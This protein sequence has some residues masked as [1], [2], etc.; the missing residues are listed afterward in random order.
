MDHL[1][2]PLRTLD[3]TSKLVF[4]CRCDPSV[5]HDGPLET[6]PERRGFRLNYWGELNFANVLTLVDG[7]RPSIEQSTILLQEWLFFGLLRV[8]HSIYGTDFD[9]NDYVKNFGGLSVLTL[10][11]LP[12]H[13]NTWFGLEGD[14]P[15]EERKRHKHEVEAHLMRALR[16]LTNNFTALSHGSISPTGLE[17]VVD[18]R[19][20]IAVEANL[21]I[22]LV[23]LVEAM[24]P[25]TKTIYFRERRDWGSNPEAICLSTRRLM[26][27]LHWCPSALNFLGL[28]FDNGSFCFASQVV[29]NPDAL[30]HFQHS[31]C[32]PNK[33]LAFHLEESTYKT[34]HTKLCEGYKDLVINS[35][36]LVSILEGSDETVVPRV[37]ITITDRNDVELSLTTRGPYVAIS[38]VW[39]DGLGHP[40]GVNSL[41]ECQVRRLK[42][43]IQETGLD[44]PLIW[45]D[46]LCVPAKNGLAKRNALTRMARV[47]GNAAK[48]LVL[49]SDLLSTSALCSN[50]EILLRI[51]LSKWMQRLW[52]LEEGVLARSRLLFQFADHP[53]P[54]PAPNPSFCD[55]IAF[56]CASL[57]SQYLPADTSILSIITALHF[58]STSR[59]ADEPVCISHI[60]DLDASSIVETGDIHL[61]MTRLYNLLSKKDPIFPWQFLF[62]DEE[63]LNTS[64]YRW[65][66][67]S[68]LNLEPYD[69]AYLQGSADTGVVATQ[70][71]R[72]LQFQGVHPSCLL[73]FDEGANIRKCMIL[74]ID[75]LSYVLCPVTKKGK[76]R[77][78]GRFWEGTDK[79]T[80]LSAEPAQDWTESWQANYGFRPTGNWG[81]IYSRGGSYGVM[82][83]VDELKDRVLYTTLIGQVH[84]YEIQTPHA[85]IVS[86]LNSEMWGQVG[87]PVLDEEE[88]RR[89]QKRVEREIFDEGH[90]SLVNCV[91]RF[92]DDVTWCVG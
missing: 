30:Q 48:I 18:E 36:E 25:V 13:V 4:P 2:E 35:A 31:R 66:P 50:E 38:H 45:I 60:L 39:S 76:C 5:S 54:L 64:P 43:L 82:V 74:R 92:D 1:P 15:R 81:L 55:N 67:A 62:T 68:L 41:P 40:F 7:S 85:S 87:L 59:N 8:I 42:S 73:N 69:V 88:V 89:D 6:Y 33:R 86:G 47:Y 19:S 44:E 90:Y 21:E 80:C 52:T 83:A 3:D 78:H 17:Y 26:E 22:L 9:G 32:T 58:R 37:K 10:E 91:Q 16:F 28:T 27:Q 11:K 24:D 53:L 29:R 14:R 63:K 46:S 75:A 72:G 49:D 79:D 77:T 65:A 51:A 61:R 84:M 56:S 70:M 20:R 57:I 12:Q 71:E 34:A 23:V